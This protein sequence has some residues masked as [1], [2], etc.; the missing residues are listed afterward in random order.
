[1]T[2][3]PVKRRAMTRSEII[4]ILARQGTVLAGLTLPPGALREKQI[5][6]LLEAQGVTV[7]CGACQE[8][9]AARQDCVRDHNIALRSIEEGLRAEYDKPWNQRYLCH[10][11]NGTKT[12]KRGL[13]GLG[14]DAARLAKL[15]RI[16]KKK[17]APEEPKKPWPTA[18]SSM[19]NAQGK[20]KIPS[21]PFPKAD[22]PIPSRPFP[23]RKKIADGG[24]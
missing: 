11:C 2:D 9:I 6:N 5:W 19:V 14:S 20:A 22:R 24:K 8:P 17:L 4:E 12:H 10:P 15:R 3:G 13:N 16:E 23:K 18:K 7:P 1:M 21:R